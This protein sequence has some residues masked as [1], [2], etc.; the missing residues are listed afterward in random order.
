LQDFSSI[1]L[2]EDKIKAID[3]KIKNGLIIG[4]VIGNIATVWCG[5]ELKYAKISKCRLHKFEKLEVD[6]EGTTEIQRVLR[7][8]ND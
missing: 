5:N 6:F 2:I 3:K 7:T 8:L 4:K 1:S